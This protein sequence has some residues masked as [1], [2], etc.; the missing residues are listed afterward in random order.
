MLRTSK[1]GKKGI[2]KS[3]GFLSA[4]PPERYKNYE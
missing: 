3:E 2:S 4:K 1:D